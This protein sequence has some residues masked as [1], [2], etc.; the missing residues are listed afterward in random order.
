M[1]E[2]TFTIQHRSAKSHSNADALSRILPCEKNGDQCKQCHKHIR[3]LFN[4]DTELIEEAIAYSRVRVLRVSSGDSMDTEAKDTLDPTSDAAPDLM[5]LQDL[6]P[7][8]AGPSCKVTSP[9]TADKFIVL[10]D[11]EDHSYISC[12]QVS[13]KPIYVLP[14]RNWM[15]LSPV[16]DGAYSTPLTLRTTR[17]I[18]S[19]LSTH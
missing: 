5:G 15:I 8:P 2:Y 9:A 18:P 13:T 7:S 10:D 19:N 16:M 6:V 12:S 1:S 17:R 11:S 4:E 3:D 14:P